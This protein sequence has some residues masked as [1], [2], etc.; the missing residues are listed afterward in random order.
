[1]EERGNAVMT[2]VTNA[3]PDG[4]LGDAVELGAVDSRSVRVWVR[5]PGATTVSARLEVAGRPAVTAS[6][7][8]SAETDWTGAVVLPLPEPAPAARFVCTVGSVQRHGW[9]APLPETHAGLTFGFGSCHRPFRVVED[10]IVPNEAAGIYPA[11]LQDLRRADAAFMLLGGDQVYSDEL[12]PISVRDKLPG[13]EQKPPPFEVALAAYRRISRGFLGQAGFR[14][15]REAVPTY[16]MWDDHDIF[17]NWGSRLEKTPLDLCLFQAASR[18]YCEYQ[19]QRNPGGTI[20]PPPYQYTF[21]YGDIGFLVLDARGARDYEHGRLLG[22]A[23]WEAIRAYL[24]G[25]DARTIQTLFV[26][27]TV[28]IAHVSRWLAKVFDGLPGKHGNQIRDRWCSDRFV[29]SR[30]SLLDALFDWEAAVPARQVFLLSGDVHAASAFTIRRK[31]GPGV[32]HQVTSSAMT[33]PHTIEQRILNTL[34]VRGANL[35]EPRFRFQFRRL[36][37]ANNYGLVRI[38]PL[39]G[40]GHRVGVTIRAWDAKRQRLRTAARL[41]CVPR[42]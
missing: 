37:Y 9:L 30:D 2:P 31:D 38:V 39:P 1:M 7:S 19:H 6:T 17:N 3:F 8:L 33:S 15:L 18:A 21:R 10:R 20:G 41:A 27:V 16:C 23:Q 5:Q 36:V 26:V 29:R 40:G 4:E 12:E 32:I 24:A 34:A 25:D 14:A 22:E 28:P 11:I 35:F 42:R 13:D